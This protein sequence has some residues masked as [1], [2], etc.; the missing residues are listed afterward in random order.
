MPTRTKDEVLQCKANAIDT[1]ILKKLNKQNLKRKFKT[2]FKT[3]RRSWCKTIILF[4]NK[5]TFM[6][7][8]KVGLQIAKTQISLPR[9][10]TVSPWHSL[11][12][13]NNLTSAYLSVRTYHL[14]FY[15]EKS[16]DMSAQTVRLNLLPLAQSDQNVYGLMVTYIVIRNFMLTESANFCSYI[17]T[18][19]P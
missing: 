16:N 12:A 5:E 19:S 1:H 9:N 15:S 6:S 2:L 17:S 7:R 3:K 18:F 10:R 14:A 11:F 8:N 13:L 4:V